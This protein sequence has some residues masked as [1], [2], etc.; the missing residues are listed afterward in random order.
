MNAEFGFATLG[1]MISVYSLHAPSV[2]W[3]FGS[4]QH[5]RKLPAMN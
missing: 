5:G 2:Y 3:S 4:Q 1:F